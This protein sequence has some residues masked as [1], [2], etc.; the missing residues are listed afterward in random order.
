MLS[1]EFVERLTAHGLALPLHKARKKVPHIGD[2]GTRVEPTSPNAIKMETFV[3]DAIP[4][5]R[6]SV[7]LE[8]DRAEEFAPIKNADGDDSP[9]T[10]I[11]AQSAR[12]A[13]WL[14]AAG[15]T[16]PRSPDGSPDCLIE[17]SP[18][19]ASCEAACARLAACTV[20][21]GDRLAITRA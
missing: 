7:V 17:L 12:A 2:D 18:L 5:A 20:A 19:A 14:E 1:R 10:S 11:A 21:R 9:A 15:W 13:R 6:S 3:F 16:I 4:M 8:T